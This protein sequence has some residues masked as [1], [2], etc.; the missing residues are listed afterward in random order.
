MTSSEPTYF[1][2]RAEFRAWLEQHHASADG[3]LV[4]YYKAGSGKPSLTWSESVEEAL[5]FGWIDGVRKGLDDERY[6]VR[7][8]PRKPG[9][10]WSALNVRKAQELI[11]L[12]RMRPAGLAAFE[13]RRADRTAVYAYEQVSPATLDEAYEQ[14]LKANAKAWAYLTASA[15][16]YRRAAVHWVMSAKQEETRRR[17]LQTL[18]DDS[19]HGRTVPPLT[20]RRRKC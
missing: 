11:D 18:I 17:R 4:G 20:P 5:C 2:T 16:S 8:T 15:P 6:Q 7:F 3:L 12:G 9:S 19:A 10:N 1:A 14:H 13:A